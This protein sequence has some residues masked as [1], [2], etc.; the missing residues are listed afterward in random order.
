MGP[1]IALVTGLPLLGEAVAAPG[2]GAIAWFTPVVDVASLVCLLVAAALAILDA[3]LRAE[4]RA[5]PVAGVAIA[6]A[7]VRLGQAALFPGTMPGLPQVVSPGDAAQLHLI[8]LAT[9]LL[10]FSVLFQTGGPLRARQWAVTRAILFGLVLGLCG[11][12]LGLLIERQVHIS[13]LKESALGAE[14]FPLAIGVIPALVGL[15]GYALGRRGDAPVAEGVMAALT[16][17]GINSVLVVYLA[18]HDLSY[19]YAS[20]V[21]SLLPG[22]ALLV[23]QVSLYA[24]SVRAEQRAAERLRRSLDVAAALALDVDLRPVIEH[25]LTGAMQAVGADRASL[26]KLEA[27]GFV[28]EAGVDQAGAQVPV[29]RRFS[30]GD[31]LADGVPIVARAVVE[32]MPS[33]SGPYQVMTLDDELRASLAELRHTLTVPL[34]HAGEVDGVLLVSR[35]QDRPFDQSDVESLQEFTSIATLMVRNA[36]LLEAAEAASRAKTSFLNMAAHELRTPLTVI[37]GYLDMLAQGSLGPLAPSQLAPLETMRIK[38]QELSDQVERLL[39]ASRLDVNQM[40]GP[41]AQRPI[42]DLVEVTRAAV[43]RAQGR[44]S[45]IEG[46]IDL[47][48]QDQS[49]PCESDPGDLGVILDNL[50]NNALTYSSGPAWVRVEVAAGENAMVSVIDRGKGIPSDERERIFEQFYRIEDPAF[51]YPPGTGLGLYIS[52][53]LAMMQG[54]S[55]ELADSIPGV[56]SRFILRLRRAQG[57]TNGESRASRSLRR[58]VTALARTPR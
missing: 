17:S 10:L 35:R 58:H 33:I 13:D 3:I 45:L 56:G 9:S 4:R 51:G 52:R 20:H 29:G 54:G 47:E 44:A 53:Q 2:Q 48:V 5:L 39:I 28:I 31:V 26:L 16:Y 50:I 57:K 25:L 12:L 21:L 6:L 32:R 36:R 22:V 1:A 15:L 43:E 37:M 55:L 18:S 49:I 11:L 23:S 19:G 38:G 27:G 8:D 24:S 14:I 40:P 30:L 46:R 34:T 42:V 7:V 41:R